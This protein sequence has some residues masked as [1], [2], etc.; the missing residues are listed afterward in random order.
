MIAGVSAKSL[1]KAVS[2]TS[3]SA[4]TRASEHKDFIN[5]DCVRNGDLPCYTS[6]SAC[7]KTLAA[8]FGVKAVPDEICCFV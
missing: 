5:T 6:S 7:C 1:R 8:H 4:V 2:V 3:Q